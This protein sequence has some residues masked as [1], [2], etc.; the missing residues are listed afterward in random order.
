VPG[1]PPLAYVQ[2]AME[3]RAGAP[4]TVRLGRKPVGLAWH[5]RGETVPAAETVPSLVRLPDLASRC[6]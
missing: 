1:L 6:R 5:G 4:A 3:A 2:A